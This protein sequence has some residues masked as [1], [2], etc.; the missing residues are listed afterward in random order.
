MNNELDNLKSTLY[1][2]AKAL[3][4][5]DPSDCTPSELEIAN[6]L[7]NAEYLIEQENILEE[8]EWMDEDNCNFVT[9]TYVEYRVNPNK[10]PERLNQ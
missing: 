3:D 6:E 5:L 8:K 2:V 9:T 10:R 1:H 7:L 4:Y